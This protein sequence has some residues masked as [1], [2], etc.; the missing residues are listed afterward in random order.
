MLIATDFNV[1]MNDNKC[2]KI[3]DDVFLQPIMWLIKCQ[4]FTFVLV[5]L[6]GTFYRIKVVEWNAE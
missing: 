4:L 2:V 3:E 6:L 5:H 1:L